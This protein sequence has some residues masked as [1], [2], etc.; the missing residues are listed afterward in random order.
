MK[1]L[2]YL[3][4]LIRNIYL[5]CSDFALK[6]QRDV[7]FEK[8]VVE[9]I[10]NIPIYVIS[11]NRLSYVSQFV[12]QLERY[13][14]TNIHIIVNILAS[15]NRDSGVVETYIPDTETAFDWL[16]YHL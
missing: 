1:Q 5:R 7:I 8:R 9:G 11:C 2:E 12:Q 13:H 6:K 15:G 4:F 3:K 16:N 14:L 10:Y